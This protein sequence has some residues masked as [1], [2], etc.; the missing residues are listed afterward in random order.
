M[1]TKWT[2]TQPLHD[3]SSSSSSR[4]GRIYPLDPVK[5]WGTDNAVYRLGEDMVLRLPRTPGTS[6]TLEMD[7]HW[8]PKLAPQ[9]PLAVPLPLPDGIPAEG[10]PFPWSVYG[11]LPGESATT[12]RTGTRGNS[13]SVTVH[14]RSATDRFCGLCPVTSSPSE[15]SRLPNATPRP[16]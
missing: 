8:L 10:Y 3:G 11:W 7:R 9:L 16:V 1:P 12:E 4:N 14:S 2:T 6:R 5:P 15:E 13:R